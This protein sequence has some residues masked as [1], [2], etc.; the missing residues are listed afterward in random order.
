MKW[1]RKEQ[2][3]LRRYKN[4]AKDIWI[5]NQTRFSSNDKQFLYCNGY[6]EI[7]KSKWVWGDRKFKA[8]DLWIKNQI[9]KKY[10][11]MRVEETWQ[12]LQRKRKIKFKELEKV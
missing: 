9:S 4:K 10:G 5:Q 1:D 8:K 2:M 11:K 3:S 7:G 6:T 12:L